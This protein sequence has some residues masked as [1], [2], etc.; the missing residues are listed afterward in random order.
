MNANKKPM[1]NTVEQALKAIEEVAA[2]KQPKEPKAEQPVEQPVTNEQSTAAEQST[3]AALQDQSTPTSV[4]ERLFGAPSAKA[5]AG[6]GM[7]LL[8]KT[9]QLTSLAKQISEKILSKVMTEENY[10]YVQA[11]MN[12]HS[13][14]D[15]LIV[16]HYDLQDVNIDFLKAEKAEE[17][18]KMLRSQQSKRSRAKGKKMD[19]ENYQNMM[20][21]AIAELLLRIAL[22]KPKEAG[23]RTSS[24]E[25]SYTEAEIEEFHKDPE[26]LKKAIR[27]VQ[28]KKSILKYSSEFEKTGGE[29]SMR[30][31]S[32]LAEEQQLKSI[33]DKTSTG[34]VMLQQALEVKAKAEEFIKTSDISNMSEEDAKKALQQLAELLASKN[35]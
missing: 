32:L 34:S 12:K 28:S 27:N 8:N 21:G 1:D 24:T 7:L 20:I 15:D 17:L 26:K 5:T 30:W 2:A 10:E 18:E 3:D 16:Q 29:Q 35:Q 25:A 19:M 13:M 9:A 11:S 6:N 31:L 33:R 23:G 4:I 22:N 14:M